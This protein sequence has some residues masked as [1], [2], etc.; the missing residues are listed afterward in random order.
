MSYLQ[1]RINESEK[2][3]KEAVE[4]FGKKMAIGFSGGT[5]SLVV[6]NMALPYMWDV[7]DIVNFIYE[8]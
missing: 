1:P 6:L 2:I 4:K 8:R 7:K 3:I 5:G